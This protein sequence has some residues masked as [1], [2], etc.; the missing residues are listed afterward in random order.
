MSIIVGV[1]FVFLFIINKILLFLSLC[2]CLVDVNKEC[3]LIHV[4]SLTIFCLMRLQFGI[5]S[6]PRI[7]INKKYK[8]ERASSNHHRVGL[9][10]VVAICRLLA[11]CVCIRFTEYVITPQHTNQYIEYVNTTTSTQTHMVAIQ[12]SVEMCNVFIRIL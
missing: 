9:L 6:L 10:V 8:Y 11:E 12:C 4:T 3:K 5:P 2:L 1:V 7:W